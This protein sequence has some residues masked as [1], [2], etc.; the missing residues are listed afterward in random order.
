MA[1]GGLLVRRQR[2]G[3]SLLGKSLLLLLIAGLIGG[4]ALMIYPFLA[5]TDRVEADV[6]VVEGWVPNYALETA[7]REFN[8]HQYKLILSTGGPVV[9]RGGYVNDYQTVAS[10]G[11]ER[12]KKLNIPAEAIKMVPC[13][14]SDRDRTY[15]SAVALREWFTDHGMAVR[16]INI[17]T[18]D[19]HARRTRLLYHKALGPEVKIGIIAVANPDYDSHRWWRSSEGVEGII[20]EA[21]SYIYVLCFFL[22]RQA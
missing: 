17:V 19:V 8:E 9:G 1:F 11:A 2:W 6:L 14:V 10:F 22:D 20:G 7:V 4:G 15:S 12:L 3:L 5:V 21:I 18:E 16:A 13:R